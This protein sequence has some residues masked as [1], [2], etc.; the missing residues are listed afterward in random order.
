MCSHV[1]W[2]FQGFTSFYT[3]AQNQQ[4]CE[5][6]DEDES[7]SEDAA[8]LFFSAQS[9]PPLD[10]AQLVLKLGVTHKGSGG[11]SSD[12]VLSFDDSNFYSLDFQQ[13]LSISKWK[14]EQ[15]CKLCSELTYMSSDANRE[16]TCACQL[17]PLYVTVTLKHVSMIIY[18][19]DKP[20]ESRLPQIFGVMNQLNNALK[21][22]RLS[23]SHGG[24]QIESATYTSEHPSELN[25]I[26]SSSNALLQQ[27]LTRLDCVSE[28]A[29]RAVDVCSADVPW[30]TRLL[31]VMTQHAAD[32]KERSLQLKTLECQLESC[33]QAFEDEEQKQIATVWGAAANSIQQQEARAAAVI[34]LRHTMEQKKQL[35]EAMLWAELMS[36]TVAL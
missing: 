14:Q 19:K 4:E 8:H 21:E 23:L 13:V 33:L 22:Q 15:G 12:V 35:E 11:I 29:I 17:L 31:H 5:E 30:M 1:I 7:L 27:F 25:S 26:V 3:I 6:N 10:P 24:R 16:N 32:V 9:P 28:S 20:N 36:A 18:S 2:L 34:A